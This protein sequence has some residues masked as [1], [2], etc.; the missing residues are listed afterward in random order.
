[1]FSRTT[2]KRRTGLRRSGFK[3][4]AKATKWKAG[5]PLKSQSK[6]KAIWN[7]AYSA[8]KCR[9]L[10]PGNV[11]CQR[12]KKRKATDGH[13]PYGQAGERIMVFVM[14]CRECHDWAH[15]EDPRAARA[16]GWICDS[17]KIDP[18]E[19]P[20]VTE[21]RQWWEQNKVKLWPPALAN[22]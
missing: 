18:I 6:K 17:I 12:C 14:V 5:K 16:E 21:A 11:K 15:F 19:A 20:A 10:S 3:P 2:L 8:E 22:A 7:R 13:H 9:R 1:M 4:K